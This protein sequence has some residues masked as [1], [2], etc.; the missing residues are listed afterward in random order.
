MPA[1]WG[2]KGLVETGFNAVVYF[3]GKLTE[4]EE[5]IAS[6]FPDNKGNTQY[7]TKFVFSDVELLAWEAPVELENNEFRRFIT[8][9]DS[10][11][12]TW[13]RTQAD[14][15]AFANRHHLEGPLPDCLKDTEFIW[16]RVEYPMGRG[17]SPGMAYIPVDLAENAEKY[18]KGLVEGGSQDTA[19][20]AEGSSSKGPKIPDSISDE[21]EAAVLAVV[22][23]DGASES[24]IKQALVG[25]GPTR[26]GMAEAGGV[27]SVIAYLVQEGKIA[28]NDGTYTLP[29]AE[30]EATDEE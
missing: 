25:K 28:D 11:R 3:K 16:G 12:S 8:Q 24:D 9:K 23:G 20:A 17:A 21:V 15:E 19:R 30:A 1:R 18:D 10:K 4:I 5:D 7:Q 6:D 13:G 27:A 29:A 22:E 2:T 26:T 14:F